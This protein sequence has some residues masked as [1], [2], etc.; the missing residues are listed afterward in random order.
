MSSHGCCPACRIHFGP[1]DDPQVC[2]R[3][4]GPTVL[5][6]AHQVLGLARFRAAPGHA[7]EIDLVALSAA[8]AQRTPLPPQASA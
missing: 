1:L 3:C 6:P 5:L 2:P 8:I 7:P 4:S